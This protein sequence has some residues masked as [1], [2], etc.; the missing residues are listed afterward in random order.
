MKATT[1]IA[2]TSKNY[3]PNKFLWH[4]VLV[5]SSASVNTIDTDTEQIFRKFTRSS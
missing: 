4:K 5:E 1:A 3:F 2:A